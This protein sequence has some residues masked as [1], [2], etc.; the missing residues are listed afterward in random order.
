MADLR[1]EPSVK[2]IT[3]TQPARGA[4]ST[5]GAVTQKTS[6]AHGSPATEHTPGASKNNVQGHLR[7]DQ[8]RGIVVAVDHGRYLQ[9]KVGIVTL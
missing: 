1:V 9:K 3:L 5:I 6:C 7:C 2:N 4:P 8:S